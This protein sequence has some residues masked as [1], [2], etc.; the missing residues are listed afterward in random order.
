MRAARCESRQSA[1]TARGPAGQRRR[2]AC[3]P[4]AVA[5]CLSMQSAECA[6]SRLEDLFWSKLGQGPHADHLAKVALKKMNGLGRHRMHGNLDMKRIAGA[7][8]PHA[9]GNEVPAT[10]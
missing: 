6:S 2:R 10:E 8:R 9:V 7:V 4:R 1:R 5:G 3:K